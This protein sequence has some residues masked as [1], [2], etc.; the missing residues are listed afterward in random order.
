MTFDL[1]TARSNL[2]PHTLYGETFKKS[3]SQNVLNTK[4]EIY[5]YDQTNKTFYFLITT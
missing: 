4:A 1:F 3:F 2:H 5:S